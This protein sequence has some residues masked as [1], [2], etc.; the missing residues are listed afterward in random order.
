MFC[1]LHSNTIPPA[2]VQV[3]SVDAN[4]FTV[5]LMQ[6]CWLHELNPKRNS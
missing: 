2:A 6:I 5:M 3:I 4:M 1:S